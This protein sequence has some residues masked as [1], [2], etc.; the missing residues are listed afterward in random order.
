MYP[1]LAGKMEPFEV[2]RRWSILV[3]ARQCHN[4]EGGYY[5]ISSG[6]RHRYIDILV[7]WMGWNE[8]GWDGWMDGRMDG[9]MYA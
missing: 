8:M 9:Q 7:D 2:E 5:G 6:N 3:L 1:L 4:K